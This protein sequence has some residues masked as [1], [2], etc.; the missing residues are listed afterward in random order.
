MMKKL[1]VCLMLLSTVILFGCS[2][3]LTVA[4]K[5]ANFSARSQRIADF[6]IP[7]THYIKDPRTG[8]CFAYDDFANTIT[9]V[10]EDKIP[11]ELLVTADMPTK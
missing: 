4:Q 5:N 11:P 10:P 9:C 7:N 2:G 8:I 6:V 1:T 3:E